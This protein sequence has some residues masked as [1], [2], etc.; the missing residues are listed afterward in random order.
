MAKKTEVKLVTCEIKREDY[1]KI[2]S[3]LKFADGTVD[4]IGIICTIEYLTAD[5]RIKFVNELYRVLK[6]GGKATI[7]TPYW[8][9]NRAYTDLAVQW[10][11]VAEGWFYHLREEWRK[12]NNPIEKRYKCDFDFTLGYGMHP[13][14]VNRNQD[15]QQDAIIF[16]KEAA[17]DMIAT[18]IK[19]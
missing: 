11:P 16:K 9:S 4:E 7:V 18:L 3:K 19:R 5:E 8:C 17:Q 10:P 2:K 14:I 13:L 15:F 6:K 12:V 1:A